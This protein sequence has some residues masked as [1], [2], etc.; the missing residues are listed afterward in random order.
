MNIAFFIFARI[1]SSRLPAKALLKLG[2]STVL[3]SILN[4]LSVFKHIKPVLL[5]SSRSIDDCL[6]IYAQENSVDVYRGELDDVSSR[7]VGAIKEF[8]VDFFFRINGDSPCI[9]SSLI[10]NALYLI[11]KNNSYHFI[12]NLINRSYPYGVALELFN[13]QSY[14]RFQK[15]FTTLQ[16]KE[17]ATSYFYRNSDK[18]HYFNIINDLDLTGYR[19]T[20]DTLDDYIRFQSLLTKQPNFLSLSLK[21]KIHLLKEL[22]ND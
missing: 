7:I 12:T 22:T 11:S 19:L 20:I 6:A 1:D 15:N 16:D 18:F 9:D 4:Q 14:I 5:T 21:E 13:A 2:Q 3:G 10:T 17:H 8:N